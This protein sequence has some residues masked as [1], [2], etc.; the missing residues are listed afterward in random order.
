M[1]KRFSRWI[2]WLPVVNAVAIGGALFVVN[3]MNLSAVW[4]DE[5]AIGVII[6]AYGLMVLC[7]PISNATS[8][9]APEME[10]TPP[11]VKTR[12]RSLGYRY[13]QGARIASARRSESQS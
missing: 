9:G 11:A 6:A 12:R 8:D 10:S 2:W 3:G 4:Q 13:P 7:L 5:A 1:R